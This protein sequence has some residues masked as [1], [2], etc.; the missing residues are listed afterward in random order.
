MI[1]DKVRA[2]LNGQYNAEL[3][4]AYLYMAMASYFE[5][6]NLKGFAK[7][8]RIQ[9]QEEAAHAQKFHDYILERGGRAAFGA[10]EAPK[11]DWDS[12]LAVFEFAY[13]HEV[14][15]TRSINNL[16]DV[17]TEAHDHATYNF[18]QW[19]VAEQVE[20]EASFDGIVQQLRL[21]GNNG[22]ALLMLDRELATRTFVPPGGA[23]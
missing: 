22:A 16:V 2:A 5:S 1:D 17:A 21:A 20:E 8:M 3:Y 9:V 10:I 14:V 12:V 13:S 19:F 18:L 7:W 11:A 4:S 23:V 6:K 15:V